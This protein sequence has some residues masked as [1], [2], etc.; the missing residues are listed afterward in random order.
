MPYPIVNSQPS[1]DS[2][3]QGLCPQFRETVSVVSDTV[4]TK[5]LCVF[6]RTMHNTWSLK[7]GLPEYSR[8]SPNYHSLLHS[9][10]HLFLWVTYSLELKCSRLGA[11]KLWFKGEIQSRTCSCIVLKVRIVLISLKCCKQNN[12]NSKKR[13]CNRE[14]AANMCGLQILK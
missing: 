2:Q 4:E 9:S 6:A 8:L 12:I 1:F 5:I 14:N 7:S 10:I 3:A 13:I 11:S